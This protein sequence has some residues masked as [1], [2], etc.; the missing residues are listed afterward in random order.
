MLSRATLRSSTSAVSCLRCTQRRSY[1]AASSASV[2]YE[3]SEAAGTKL[4]SKNIPGPT[5]TL[6]L[7]AKAGT[8]Y[9]WLPGLSE[10]L[11][12]FA[13]KNTQ[14][15]FAVRIVRETEL[16]G[17]QF[18]ANRTREAVVFGAKF[19]RE[20]LPYF[21]ELFAE[22]ASETKYQQYMIDE[23]INP[24]IDASAHK[25]FAS[26]AQIALET[27]HSVAFHR[28]LGNS[29]YPIPHLVAEEVEA[30]AAAAYTKSNIALVSAGVDPSELSKWTGEFFKSLPS[31]APSSLPSLDAV[32]SKY[33]G[34]ET[35]V[36]HTGGNAIVI[37]FPGTSLSRGSAYKPEIDALATLLG[38]Q[39]SIKWSAGTS[40]LSKVVAANPGVSISTNST[41]YTDTGLLNITISGPAKVV[42]KAAKEAAAAIKS[43]S[44]GSPAAEDVKKA[45][46]QAKFKAFDAETAD[47][48]AIDLIG[49]SAIT[50]TVQTSEES[51]KAIAGLKESALKSAAK[52]L[53]SGKATVVAV[54]D[55]SELP[56]AEEL[57]LNV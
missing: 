11:A 17:S 38:G 20:D 35:R 33:Y 39:P 56:Y 41:Q 24:T 27:A 28:G 4:I 23:V 31:S 26:P 43:A 34:G 13:F 15:R 47:I 54:G 53:F 37:A 5:S 51:L 45:L 52:G 50:G 30:Y 14:K 12:N 6:A 21:V 44:E 25:F 2:N 8:R 40:V 48:P 7:V 57:G 46:A 29:T 36:A 22:I 55:L 3:A 10:G 19:M 49:L 18:F 16:L 1:A 32:K 42:A 9:Q